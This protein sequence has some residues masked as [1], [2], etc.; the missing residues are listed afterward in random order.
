MGTPSPQSVSSTTTTK[1]S[2]WQ[3]IPVARRKEQQQVQAVKKNCH[4]RDISSR[5]CRMFKKKNLRSFAKYCPLIS[6]ILAPFSTLMDIPALSQRWYSQNG[7]TQ[8]DPKASLALSGVGLGLNV[9][10]NILLVIRFSSKAPFWVN[11]STKWSLYC[12]L[13]KTVVAAVNLIVFGI[14]TRNDV[15]YQYLEGFWCAIVSFIGSTIISFTLLFHYFLAFGHSKSDNW[16]V[17]SQGRRFMLSVTV[18]IAILGVQSLVFSR[19]EDWEYVDGIYMSVQTALTIGY[20]DYVPTTTAGKVLIFPFS[21]LTISQLGNEIALIISFISQRAEER[22][23]KWRLRFERAIHR[24]ANSMRPKAGLMEEMALVYKINSREELMTQLYDL[25]WSAISLIVFWLLGATAFSQI[26]GWSY[27]NAMYMVMVLSLTIGFGDYVPVQPA[28][29]VVF[30]VYALMAVPIVTSFAVQTITGLLS[31]FSQHNVNRETF[32]IEQQRSPEAFAPHVDYI[33]RYHKSYADLRDKLL[34]GNIAS[35]GLDARGESEDDASEDEDNKSGAGAEAE[36]EA[37]ANERDAS[38]ESKRDLQE[39]GSTQVDVHGTQESGIDGVIDQ[40][41]E[42]EKEDLKEDA[43]RE[44]DEQSPHPAVVESESGDRFIISK[45]ERKLEVDL[46]KQLLAKT[47]SFEV[48]ARQMLLDS[49]QK[50]VERTILLAD[51]NVQIRDVKAI[52]GDDASIVSVWAGE[53]QAQRNATDKDKN[54]K[55]SSDPGADPDKE[56]HSKKSQSDMLTKVINYRS[57]F[58]EIL[59]L[60]GILQKLEGAELKQ[61]ER[62]RG[63][64]LKAENGR[65]GGERRGE[66]EEAN[67]EIREVANELAEGD[68]KDMKVLGKE[69]WSGLMKDLIKRQVKKMRHKNGWDEENMV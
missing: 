41:R 56:H 64:L 69:R 31:T 63:S 22:R 51:R 21:V 55:S 34:Q 67:G 25:I 58:A 15:S 18:F 40:F 8:P 57:L 52:R 2:R 4:V 38:S 47:V 13:G 45:E 20:G 23:K 43:R 10:A 12:W 6:A 28:G 9:I 36:S 62:W 59:V 68:A 5:S 54:N 65:D 26:E 32:I 30:I 35:N 24:E 33:D 42:M 16:D 27:G 39:E 11:H 53:E 60:G 14:L 1:P 37:E 29:K 3:H 46:L 50:G 48:E 17:R 66:D 19:I 44:E 7:V 61:F 49:M